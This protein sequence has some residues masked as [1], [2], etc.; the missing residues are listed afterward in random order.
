VNEP[1]NPPG[2]PALAG[3][4]EQD[5]NKTDAL[6][7]LRVL[8]RQHA[9]DTHR[10]GSE[11]IT[12]TP[13]STHDANPRKSV[14][15]LPAWYFSRAAGDSEFRNDLQT[16]RPPW[17]GTR[18]AKLILIACSSGILVFVT[19]GLLWLTWPLYHGGG[20]AAHPQPATAANPA[21]ST[22]QNPPLSQPGEAITPAAPTTSDIQPVKQAMADCDAE[23]AGN[24]DAL[25]FLVIPIMPTTETA[26]LMIPPGDGYASFF[27]VM[28]SAAMESLTDGSYKLDPRPFTF[29]VMDTTTKKVQSWTSPGGLS[30]YVQDDAAAVSKFLLG[31]GIAESNIQWSSEYQRRKGNCYW[32]NVRFRP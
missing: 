17:L 24:P 8:A 29:S 10:E 11:P 25:Y 31:F 21:D 5:S 2:E 23:A 7:L 9:G 19:I 14:Q 28:S 4:S 6:S 3:S 20:R 30:K 12:E 22:P 13:H 15:Q 27:L 32:V 18:Q 26:K 1:P 16:L